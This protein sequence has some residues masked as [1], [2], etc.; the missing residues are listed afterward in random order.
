MKHFI[1]V[2]SLSLVMLGCNAQ[3]Q[4]LGVNDGGSDSAPEA[5]TPAP[6]AGAADGGISDAPIAHDTGTPFID[7]GPPTGCPAIAPSEGAT[8]TADTFCDYHAGNHNACGVT[9]LCTS[10][11]GWDVTE[12]GPT[13]SGNASQCPSSFGALPVGAACPGSAT[14]RC[15]YEEGRCGCLGCTGGSDWQCR[16]WT[17]IGPGCPVD[18]PVVG[19][20]CGFKDLW[21]EYGALI[22]CDLSLGTSITCT[23]GV[24]ARDTSGGGCGGRTCGEAVTR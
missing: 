24:W 12:P 3:L 18:Q 9:A 20:A 5:A 13:C 21:C 19:T 8:C 17:D 4:D 23:G 14:L 7:A 22:N 11:G 1:L 10:G 2:P 16:R 15:D 6:E